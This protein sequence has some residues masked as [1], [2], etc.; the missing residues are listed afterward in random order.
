MKLRNKV[1][2]VVG[3]ARGIGKAV[4]LAFA[5]EG[6]D[7]LVV[8][9]SKTKYPTSG[10]EEVSEKLRAMGRKSLSFDIDVSDGKQVKEMVKTGLDAFGR[11]D[12][13]TNVAAI[14]MK[15]AIEDLSEQD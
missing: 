11:I 15:S 2:I 8:G 4:S 3:G 13:L 12:V 7:V 6:S 10:S 5:R 14:V 1:S 9:N